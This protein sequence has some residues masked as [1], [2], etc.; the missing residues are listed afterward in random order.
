[1][2]GRA[3]HVVGELL[4]RVKPH[5]KAFYPGAEAKKA[6]ITEDIVVAQSWTDLTRGPEGIKSIPGIPWFG[7]EIR[8]LRTY[9]PFGD[10]GPLATSKRVSR[11]TWS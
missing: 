5:V 11:L 3:L 4:L 6:L 1:M 9:H 7:T 8:Q 10:S 2:G